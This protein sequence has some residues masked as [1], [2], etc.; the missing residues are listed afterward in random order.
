MLRQVV[1]RTDARSSSPRTIELG[2]RARDGCWCAERLLALDAVPD[3][4]APE[5]M[6]RCWIPG[7]DVSTNG[8]TW[9]VQNANTLR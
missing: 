3:G 9:I 5:V 2:G 8:R 7:G 1:D 6:Q 4:S